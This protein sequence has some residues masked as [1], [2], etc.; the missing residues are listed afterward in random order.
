MSEMKSSSNVDLP[1]SRMADVTV[2]AP[3]PAKNLFLLSSALS[4]LKFKCAQPMGMVWTAYIPSS[5]SK[6]Q[7]HHMR[8]LSDPSGRAPEGHLRD[9]LARQCES[10]PE[11]QVIEERI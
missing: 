2:R 10:P 4:G 7:H 3:G 9:G 11:R 8:Q 1:S 5:M 6:F